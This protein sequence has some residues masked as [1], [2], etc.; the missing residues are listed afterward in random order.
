MGLRFAANLSM[1]WT[2]TEPYGRFDA[3]AAAGFRSVEML[4]PQELDTD[5][6][7]ERLQTLRLHMALFDLNAGDWAAGERGIAALPDRVQEF[8]DRA[9]DDLALA[10]ELGTPTLAVLAGKR[11]DE[12]PADVADCTLVD[13]LRYV[14]PLA[15]KQGVTLTLE[16]INGHDVP[17]FH[18]RLVEHAAHVIG[19]VN[20]PAVRMQ[21]DQYHVSREGQN[22]VAEYQRHRGLIA[23]IQI[24]D[25]PGR[26][27]PGTGEAPIAAFLD[28][29]E[30]DG[31]DG[32]I[33][34][35]FHPSSDED[36]SLTWLGREARQRP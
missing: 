24:A 17:G 1:L 23:H 10:R 21:F 27:E 2:D 16:A 25:A 29:V 33:G 28:E 6:V 7:A 13:N 19:L 26:H 15:E 34:L 14:A 3:A 31:Y 11:P 36:S 35:E 4:F 12:V 32:V 20:H 5:R 22:P 30:A 8:R 18:L 9:I